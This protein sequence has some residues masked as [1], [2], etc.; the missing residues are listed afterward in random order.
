M[1]F[2]TWLNRQVTKYVDYEK[3]VAQGDGADLM[4]SGKET[5]HA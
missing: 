5:V 2:V 1:Y 4:F 3:P